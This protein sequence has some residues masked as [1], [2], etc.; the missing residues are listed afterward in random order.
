MKRVGYL[1]EKVIDYDNIIGAMAD[2][3]SHRP[4]C[5]RRGIDYRLAWEL[6]EKM[7][8]D[9]AAVIGKP[10]V[11]IIHEYGKERRLEIPSYCSCIAQLALWRVCEPYVE[12]RIHTQSFSSRKGYG[13]HKAAKKC[14]RFIH[15]HGDD[16]AKYCL[17][18]DIKKFYQHIRKDKVMERLETVFKDKR[19]LDMFRAVVYSTEQ[20]LP[21][22]YQFSHALANLYLVPLYFLLRCVKNVSKVFVYMDNWTVFSRY[23]K[24]L[25]RAVDLARGWLARMGCAIKSDWQIFPTVARGV[26]ICGFVIG[27]GQTRLYRGNWRRTMRD[28]R[29]AVGMDDHAKISMASRR[30]WLRSINREYSR[31]FCT[32]KGYLWQQR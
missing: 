1:Y 25:H 6:K 7:E 27:R 10:R 21:I 18:F 19:V 31:C 5:L 4:V 29:R 8:T 2:Y 16:K 14:E 23:K 3:D 32:E 28:F 17:Y 30:G 15:Q 20:G 13:G 12:K 9:F 22:G 26:K 24:A 11:K